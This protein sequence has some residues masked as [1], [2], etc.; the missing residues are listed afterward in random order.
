MVGKVSERV[1]LREGKTTLVAFRRLGCP[2]CMLMWSGVRLG[3]ERTDNGMK[4][5]SWP[6]VIPINQKN[7]YTYVRSGL[8]F[9]SALKRSLD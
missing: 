2:A 5:S 8:S 3:L 9:S 7:Y 1:L 6:D 4:Q